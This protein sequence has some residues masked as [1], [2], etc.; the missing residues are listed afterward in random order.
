M[1]CGRLC[2]SAPEAARVRRGP[3]G[4]PAVCEPVFCAGLVDVVRSMS[5]A[6]LAPDR[7][8]GVDGMDLRRG[9]QL[10]GQREGPRAHVDGK[11]VST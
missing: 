8:C 1:A 11:A 3:C 4:V 6:L 9:Q 2:D 7:R 10:R 5:A